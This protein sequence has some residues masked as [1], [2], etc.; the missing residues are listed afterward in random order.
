MKNNDSLTSHEINKPIIDL[1]LLTLVSLEVA[2]PYC[3]TCSR[4]SWADFN[5]IKVSPTWG[6][7]H[8]VPTNAYLF[9]IQLWKFDPLLFATCTKFQDRKIV[10]TKARRPWQGK[11]ARKFKVLISR[12]SPLILN[13]RWV[14]AVS[15]WTERALCSPE[16]YRPNDCSIFEP[17]ELTNRILPVVCSSKLSLSLPFSTSLHN[18]VSP[19]CSYFLPTCSYGRMEW[20]DS[21]W[22]K[23]KKTGKQPRRWLVGSRRRRRRG[24]DEEQYFNRARK[25]GFVPFVLQLLPTCTITTN[26]YTCQT[27]CVSIKGTARLWAPIY[28][29]LLC[30]THHRL[31]AI[32]FDARPTLN[33]ELQLLQKSTKILTIFLLNL[34]D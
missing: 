2:G 6:W 18:P 11:R 1:G 8:R 29:N 16:F 21:I 26:V 4:K 20:R 34:G 9:C 10:C 30:N 12:G 7:L 15:T 31:L 32:F 17:Y 25:R 27:L 33:V 23:K 14:T 28:S 5:R 22:K 24:G 13:V 3:L 19:G